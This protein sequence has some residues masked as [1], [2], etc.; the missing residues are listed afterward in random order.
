MR[1]DHPQTGVKIA[2]RFTLRT[3]FNWAKRRRYVEH[4]PCDGLTKPHKDRSRDRVLT[5][6]EIRRLWKET[7]EPTAFNRVVRLCLLLGQRRSEI[8]SIRPEWIAGNILTFPK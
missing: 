1:A 8:A 6:D 3:L 4:S 5:H 7:A 2:R